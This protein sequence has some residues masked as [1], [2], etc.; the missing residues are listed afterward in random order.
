[1]LA[2]SPLAGLV[3]LSLAG[4]LGVPASSPAQEPSTAPPA[5]AAPREAPAV[6]QGVEV[7]ARGPVHEAFASLAADPKPTKPIPR[8]PPKPVE[9]VPPEEKPEGDVLWISGYWA[10]DDERSDFLWVSGVWRTPPPGKRWVPGYW[11]E[12]GSQWQWVAGFWTVAGQ[13]EQQEQEV[14]YLPE[15]PK[16]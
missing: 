10:W 8:Q 12:D 1:M 5:E 16:A 7:L 3:L 9:E 6:P 11:R 14:T 2:R 13:A 15:P 4:A